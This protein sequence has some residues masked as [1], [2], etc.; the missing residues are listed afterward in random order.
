M[1]IGRRASIGVADTFPYLASGVGWARV[2]GSLTAAGLS[3]VPALFGTGP[4]IDIPAQH[5]SFF[6]SSPDTMGWSSRYKSVLLE[7]EQSWLDETGDGRMK[8]A[9]AIAEHV[10][11][12]HKSKK[13]AG[14]LPKNLVAVCACLLWYVP[15]L[16][17]LTGLL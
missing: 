13:L 6:L 5:S 2:S 12:F 3:R 1:R 17:S 10:R 11:T 9:E 16:C 7:H 4:H 14:K 8:A 15:Q